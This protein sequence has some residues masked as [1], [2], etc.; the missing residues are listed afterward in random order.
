MCKQCNT[1]ARSCK[2]CCTEKAM[3]ITYYECVFVALVIQHAMCTPHIVMSPARLYNT[4]LI[5]GM[6]FERKTGVFEHKISVLIFSTT[7][8]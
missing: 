3:S 2:H 5:N 7:F 4:Y 1:D 8:I 6:M